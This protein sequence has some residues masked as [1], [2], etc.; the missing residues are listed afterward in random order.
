MFFHLG[1]MPSPP[2]LVLQEHG[3]DAGDFSL[4]K[5]LD[6]GDVVA[7]ADVEDGAKTALMKML[8]EFDVAVGSDPG[9]RA[10]EKGGEDHS[11]VYA[12]L[13]PTSQVLAVPHSFAESAEGAAC[14]QESVVDIPVDLGVGW[15]SAAQAGE[16]LHQSQ[17]SFVDGDVKCVVFFLGR[18][19]VKNLSL[20]EADLEAKEL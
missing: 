3:F 17:L 1:N 9:L 8:E 2:K 11:S 13:C 4:F 18:R 16:L 7:A 12:D 14:L 10:I 15:D 20:P 6:I 19:L 5:D